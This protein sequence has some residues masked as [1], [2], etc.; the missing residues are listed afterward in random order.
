MQGRCQGEKTEVKEHSSPSFTKAS[1]FTKVIADRDI[2]GLRMHRRI[3]M[4]GK[5]KSLNYLRF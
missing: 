4:R 5:F 1:A 2:D 3:A